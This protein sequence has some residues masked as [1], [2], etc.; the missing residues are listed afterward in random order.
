MELQGKAIL[1]EG[2]LLE[3]ADRCRREDQLRMALRENPKKTLE[4]LGVV[5]PNGLR[6][7]MKGD[8][9]ATEGLYITTNDELTDED[10]AKVAGG[11]SSLNSPNPSG[12]QAGSFDARRLSGGVM[13]IMYGV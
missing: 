12:T 8:T 6:L 9:P 7:E 2:V 13:I 1:D 4:S 3:I 11:V 5:I 10:L